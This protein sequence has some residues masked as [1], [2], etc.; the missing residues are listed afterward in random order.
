MTAALR[1]VI[2][3]RAGAPG[4]E[5]LL[6]GNTREGGLG[7]SI[8][9]TTRSSDVGR[10]GEC[11]L[12]IYNLS[13]D[14]AGVFQKPGNLVQ[15]SAGHATTTVGMAFQGNPVPDTFRE[16]RMGGDIATQVT[17]R[18]G[19]RA[20]DTGRASVSLRGRVTGRQVLDEILAQSG[21]GEGQV[22]LQGVEWPRRY[23][24][25][26]TASR[27]LDELTEA[28]GPTYAWFIRDGNVY[29]LDK[30]AKTPETAP[31]FSSSEA[32]GTLVGSPEPV[33][34]GGVRFRGIL[35]T[36]VRVG[37]V[38]SL[39]SRRYNGYYKV[40]ESSFN[41]DNFGQSFYVDVKGVPYAT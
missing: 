34:G 27:A 32:V 19:G 14:S 22:D 30:G 13:P 29:I 6:F 18:D 10:P 8:S 41:A 3:V 12:S 21:F 2:Q 37:R 16:R 39:E 1:R 36:S 7:H 20:Y 31:L 25:D 28:V 24:F 40:V 9:F 23:V 11:T 33:E 5:G 4:E 17:L 35:D 38:V 26:G 15:V